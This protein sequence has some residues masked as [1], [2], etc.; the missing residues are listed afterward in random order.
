M[1][2][3]NSLTEWDKVWFD[4]NKSLKVWMGVFESLKRAAKDV[5][6]KYASVMA[7]ALKNSNE[8]TLDQFTENWQKSI[9]EAGISTSKQFS[10]EW[11]KVFNQSAMEQVKT[12][13]EMMHKF[14]ETWQ[15]MWNKK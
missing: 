8:K 1:S 15:R 6:S 10:D 3:D 7:E 9:S 13:G 14:A 11:L 5:Q 12:Y 2:K 4:Y